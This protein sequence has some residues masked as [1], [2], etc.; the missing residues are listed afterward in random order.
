[1]TFPNHATA[2]FGKGTMTPPELLRQLHAKYAELAEQLSEALS[3]DEKRSLKYYFAE[4]AALAAEADMGRPADRATAW[5][6]TMLELDAFASRH[7]R[8]PR[9][10]RR[11][12]GAV[13]S[14]EEVRLEQWLNYQTRPTTVSLGC[15]YQADRLALITGFSATRFND[16]WR[17]QYE[18]YRRFLFERQRAPLLRSVN[19]AERA[20]AGWAA[21]QRLHRRNGSLPA[22]RHAALDALPQW[23][24]GTGRS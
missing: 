11:P 4:V 22:D 2:W 20:L 14:T 12:T 16:R 1:M 3:P 5:V 24:W 19:P 21:K 18:G 8:L 10:N 7:G 13:A 9:V 17:A 6:A 23:A 15:S